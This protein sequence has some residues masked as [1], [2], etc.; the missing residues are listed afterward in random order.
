M[1]WC[2][3]HAAATRRSRAVTRG[4]RA[5]VARDARCCRWDGGCRGGQGVGGFELD[6]AETGS[7]V[8]W[9]WRHWFVAEWDDER[10]GAI[11]EYKQGARPADWR[12]GSRRALNGLVPR[13]H[14]DALTFTRFHSLPIRALTAT[15]KT[16]GIVGDALWCWSSLSE[17]PDSSSRRQ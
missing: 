4:R 9:R 6:L 14:C 1:V 15:R 12:R 8:I 17:L 3:G 7:I 16:V 5:V 13:A 2:I 11:N 10:A